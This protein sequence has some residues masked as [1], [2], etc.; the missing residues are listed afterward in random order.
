VAAESVVSAAATPTGREDAA[1]ALRRTGLSAREIEVL[2]LVAAGRTNGEI[3]DRLY[4]SRKTAGVH[5]THI[6]DKLAVSNR[7]EAAMVAARLGL[8]P[9]ADEEAATGAGPR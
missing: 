7:V 6:L 9:A 8:A 4:I 1:A 5:V 2:Q 3:A